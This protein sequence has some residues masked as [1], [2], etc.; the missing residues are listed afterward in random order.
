MCGCMALEWVS[1]T[2]CLFEIGEGLEYLLSCL[3]AALVLCKLVIIERFYP[4]GRW[5]SPWCWGSV[6]CC[7]TVPCRCYST[8]SRE[9]SWSQWKMIGSP[10]LLWSIPQS[11]TPPIQVFS[12]L[13]MTWSS[14][15]K[16]EP[17]CLSNDHWSWFFSHFYEV[18]MTSIL[19]SWTQS[20]CFC[21]F[22]CICWHNSKLLMSC[23]PRQL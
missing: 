6:L 1:R 10:S 3:I 19:T 18:S 16:T 2:H 20:R 21:I 17:F 13:C 5:V 8:H 4:P 15:S 7:F 14:L 12:N 9:F 23:D 22:L 11:T